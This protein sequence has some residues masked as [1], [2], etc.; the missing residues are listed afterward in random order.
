MESH[1][2]SIAAQNQS[3]ENYFIARIYQKVFGPNSLV[4]VSL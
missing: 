3:S 2:I 4:E 1:E